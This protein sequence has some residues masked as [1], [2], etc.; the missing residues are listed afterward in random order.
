M[1]RPKD[2]CAD[3]TLTA[4]TRWTVAGVAF[5]DVYKK[6]KIQHEFS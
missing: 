6:I 2:V 3:G 4:Q 5:V 1:M